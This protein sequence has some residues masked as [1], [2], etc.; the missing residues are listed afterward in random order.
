MGVVPGGPAWAAGPDL[1]SA[2]EGLGA[3]VRLPIPGNAKGSLGGVIPYATLG[4][5]GLLG[6]G[7]S[8]ADWSRYQSLA[9]PSTPR[10]DVGTGLSFHLFG[11]LQVFGEYRLF[12]V[13][14][15]TGSGPAG[16][17]RESEGPPL[18]AGFSV[19]F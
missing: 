17:R 4:I 12:Q 14:P 8:R 2:P 10:V 13:R 7:S 19:P 15:E 9:G 1:G 18:R 6:E 3:S 5:S 16:L 11:R